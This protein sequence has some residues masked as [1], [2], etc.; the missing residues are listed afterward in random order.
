MPEN[1]LEKDI[2][3]EMELILIGFC[4]TLSHPNTNLQC[5]STIY[6]RVHNDAVLHAVNVSVMSS[7]F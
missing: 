7:Y 5:S 6:I 2:P 3:E 4:K 1:A